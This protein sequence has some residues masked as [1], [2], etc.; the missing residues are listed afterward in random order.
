MSS[1][2]LMVIYWDQYR[3]GGG[4]VEREGGSGDGGRSDEGLAR[5]LVVGYRSM[6]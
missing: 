5:L 2:L 6:R 3:D 1:E 4:S